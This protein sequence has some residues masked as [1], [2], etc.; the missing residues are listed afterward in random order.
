M[1]ARHDGLSNGRGLLL[2]RSLPSPPIRLCPEVFPAHQVSLVPLRR[3]RASDP[4]RTV[5]NRNRPFWLFGGIDLRRGILIILITRAALDAAKSFRA[6]ELQSASCETA[7]RGI[8]LLDILL[9]SSTTISVYLS[10][11]GS[12]IRSFYL[13]SFLVFTPPLT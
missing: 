12:T 13:S 6:S 11:F 10:I 1:E 3:H 2:S 7:A 5:K 9:F 4:P 8:E